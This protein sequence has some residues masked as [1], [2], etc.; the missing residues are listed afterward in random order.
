MRGTI[1]GEAGENLTP[2]DIVEFVAAFST[3]ILETTDN[4]VIAIGRDGR[5]SGSVI[6]NI[7]ANTLVMM[8]INVVDTGLSTTPTLAMKVLHS[9]ASGGIM[10]TASHNGENWNALKFFNHDGEF[11]SQDMG[12]RLLELSQARQFTFCTSHDLG[13]IEYDT[14]SVEAHVEAILQLSTV[15]VD[16]IKQRKFHVA[17]DCINSTG[18]LGIPSLL[19]ALGCT[20]TLLNEEIT[21]QFEHDPEPLEKNLSKL[22]ALVKDEKADLGVAVDPDVDRLAFMDEKGSYCG[23]EYTLVMVADWLLRHQTGNTVS[24]LSSTIALRKLTEHYGGTYAASPVGE[25]HVVNK[26]KE[27]MALIGGEGNGGVIYPA[28]H[29]GRDALVGIALILSALTE[30]DASLS[31]YRSKFPTYY[32]VKDKVPLASL[33]SADR[34][35][36]DVAS[37]FGDQEID[38]ADGVKVYFDDGWTHLRKSNTEPIVRLYSEGPSQDEAVRLANRV[39]EVIGSMTE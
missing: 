34:I 37:H 35:L 29:Y 38:R 31:K 21:G 1:G 12:M 32:M 14:H 16:A 2:I 39:K 6:S 28:L 25:V 7:V 24:N 27:T 20:Y 9:E 17:V 8:G 26:M 19:D 5:I 33:E 36:E 22:S 15:S 18:A 30:D 3:I 10:I 11:I 23:E 4:P 13:T